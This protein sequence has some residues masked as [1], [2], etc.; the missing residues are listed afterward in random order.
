MPVSPAG[1]DACAT[2]EGDAIQIL[3]AEFGAEHYGF[4]PNDGKNGSE[5]TGCI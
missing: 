2:S 1:K 4:G 3:F 5:L